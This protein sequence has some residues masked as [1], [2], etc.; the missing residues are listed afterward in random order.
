[1]ASAAAKAG[2]LSFV[3]YLGL[4]RPLPFTMSAYFPVPDA[5]EDIEHLLEDADEDPR[6]QLDKTIDRIGMGSYQWTLLCLCG[7]GAYCSVLHGQET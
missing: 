2:S 4:P 5:D 3:S 1:M 7:F 6:T